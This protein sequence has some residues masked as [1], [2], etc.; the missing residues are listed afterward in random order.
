[1]KLQCSSPNYGSLLNSNNEMSV[2]KGKFNKSLV[3]KSFDF[4]Q[5]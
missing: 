1:M 2:D 4:I 5:G 3:T